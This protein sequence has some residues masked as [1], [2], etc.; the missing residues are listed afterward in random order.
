MTFEIFDDIV[1][2]DI[3]DQIEDALLGADT[4]WRFSR[5]S[6][7]K[8]EISPEVSDQQRNK[9]TQ[10]NHVVFD[11]R[12]RNPNYELY[13]KVVNA[14][15]EKQNLKVLAITN[16]RS[17]LQLPVQIRGNGIPHVDKRDQKS[18]KVCVYYVNNSDGDTVLY[19]QTTANTS[20]EDIQK[21]L[22]EELV[23]VS[24]KKGRCVVFD[25]DIYHRAGMPSVD[26]RCILNY[27]FYFKE[28]I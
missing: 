14:V 12:I 2:V 18:F 3:Q 4:N 27:N 6:A 24:P 19:K 22:V 13:A 16:M 26:I 5:R 10:F 21:G 20:P 7:Y 1:S 11:G 15:A 25:G 9:I 8:K 28:R 17:H 23:R